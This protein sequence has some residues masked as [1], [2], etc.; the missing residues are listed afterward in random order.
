MTK[1]AIYGRVSTIG[2][3]ISSQVESLEKYAEDQ[4]WEI[5]DTFIDDGIS[6]AAPIEDKP[7]FLRLF[8]AIVNQDFDILLTEEHD[9]ITR[10]DDSVVY[11]T[12]IEKLKENNIPLWSPSEGICDLS[13]FSGRLVS[14]FKF[15]MG[16]E[17]R[18]KIKRRTHRG[19][20]QKW[21]NGTC[22]IGNVPFG[23][24]A[25]RKNG[26]RTGKVE[27][28]APESKV[29]KKIFSLYTDHNY[30]I[31]DVAN[32]LNDE[33][34][35]TPSAFKGVKNR[36]DLWFTSTVRKILI[37]DSYTGVAF[38]N[39]KAPRDEWVRKEFPPIISKKQFDLVQKRIKF[40]KKKAKK[41]YYGLEEKW[42]T[43]HVLY[44]AECGA[45]M[46]KKKNVKKESGKIYVSYVC[47]FK[48]MSAKK[49]KNFGRERCIM[50]SV[51][52][53]KIDKEIFFKISQVLS[54]PSRFA[55]QWLKDIDRVELKEKF[56]NFSR[57]VAEKEKTIK[58]AYK[59]LAKITNR[60]LRDEFL[61]DAD[62][63]ANELDKLKKRLRKAEQDYNLYQNK[64]DRLTQFKK[65]MNKSVKAHQLKPSL[66]T[67]KEFMQFLYDLPFK[68]KKRI[69][70]AVI[71]PENGGRCH[72]RYQTVDDMA[73]S[74]DYET[75][76]ISKKLSIMPLTD[77]EPV[78]EMDFEM[79]LNKIEALIT[80][81]NRKNLLSNP[82]LYLQPRLPQT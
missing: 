48:K 35:P 54:N 62:Q 27:K 5:D 51:S 75:F 40:N 80:G 71:A 23:Y 38:F 12:I 52:A 14:Q 26:K 4:G 31:D 47:E 60:K 25:I 65:A 6:G 36:T 64:I 69:V 58:N 72:L 28:C 39:K 15:M 73:S 63:D 9:R 42:L 24:R 44:C 2:Q 18:L 8:E 66:G 50:R 34:M 74:F 32:I 19:R 20:M 55:E 13:T 1:C 67:Q 10:D 53:D 59:D 57:Q 30:S 11:A 37:R 76:R 78:I 77:L 22:Y 68:E 29:V 17:E 45:K 7:D 3:D 61:K 56:E 41:K 16:A 82:D 21:K 33:G 49:L 46:A 43:Q 79:D 70:E 81:L